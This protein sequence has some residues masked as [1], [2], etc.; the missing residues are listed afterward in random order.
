MNINMLEIFSI[1]SVL[2]L[3]EKA[4]KGLK[5]RFRDNAETGNDS[6]ESFGTKEI[7]VIKMP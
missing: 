4:V 5:E 2:A 7:L 1:G 6:K 3:G